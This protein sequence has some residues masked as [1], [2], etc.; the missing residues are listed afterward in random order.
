[1]FKRYVTSSSTFCDAHTRCSKEIWSAV[2]SAPSPR[3]SGEGLHKFNC[4]NESFDGSSRRCIFGERSAMDGEARSS[5]L[6]GSA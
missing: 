2:D 1:M 6:E 3:C 4:G 5:L